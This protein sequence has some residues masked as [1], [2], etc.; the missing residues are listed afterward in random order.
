MWSWKPI[1]TS[2]INRKMYFQPSVHSLWLICFSCLLGSK[3]RLSQRTE[4]TGSGGFVTSSIEVAAPFVT[5]QSA[6]C[7]TVLRSK[8]NWSKQKKWSMESVMLSLRTTLIV[9][10][11]LRQ[12]DLFFMNY[13]GIQVQKH[14]RV[15]LLCYESCFCLNASQK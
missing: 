7:F 13:E 1:K 9:V 10:R 12:S 5:S 2:T 14:P 8:Q 4:P 3:T 11:K 15:S 6:V